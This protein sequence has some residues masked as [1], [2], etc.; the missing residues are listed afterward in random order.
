M[1][2]L[3]RL[4]KSNLYRELLLKIDA[5]QKRTCKIELQELL[6]NGKNK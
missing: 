1:P 6:E 5:A 2:A 4:A 3:K